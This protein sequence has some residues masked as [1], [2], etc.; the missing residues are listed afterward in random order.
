MNICVGGDLDGEVIN[1]REGTLFKANEIDASKKSTY[2][3]QTY[4]VEGNTYRFWL[5][6]ELS[7]ME[8]TEIAGKYLA[9]KYKYLS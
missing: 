6:S 5:C 7:Y 8:A 3:R 1:T 4:I 9:E 2:N